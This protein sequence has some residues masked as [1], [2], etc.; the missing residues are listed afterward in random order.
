VGTNTEEEASV[1]AKGTNVRSRL[2][3]DAEDAK[4]AIIVELEEL[5]VVDSSD[6]ELALDGRD[7]GRPL[8]EGT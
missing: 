1:D 8:E 7:E 6:A 2:A 5:D 3:R 4:P